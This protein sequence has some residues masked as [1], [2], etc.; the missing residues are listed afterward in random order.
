MNKVFFLF[1]LHNHQPVGN[2]GHIF[3]QA[4]DN[5]YHPLLE[6]LKS[7]PS[8]KM[9]LHHSGPLIEWLEK[10]RPSYFKTLKGMVAKGQ[11][12]ILSGGFYEPILSSLPERDAVGQ[13]KMMNDW[14]KKT[15]NTTPRGAWLAERI[16]DS[17][18]PS[19]LAAAG[20]EYTL[21]DDTHFE[22]AGLSEKDMYGYW[23]TERH[24]NSVAV[25][26]IDKFLRYSIPFKQ[27]EETLK[28]W[29]RAV[30]KHGTIS[31][32]Y[33]DDGEK[34]GVWPETNEWVFGK[35]W[36]ERF[37][38]MV[39]ENSELVETATYS[40]YIDRCPPNGRVYLPPASYEEMMEWSLP[41]EVSK[42]FRGIVDRLEAE[43]RK[44]EFS[45]F[46]RGGQWDN[47]MVK[48]EEANQLHKKMLYISKRAE[49][50]AAK[51]KD[52]RKNSAIRREL[53]QG[54]CNCPYWH[55]LFGGLYLSNLRHA[56]YTH[57]IGSGKLSDA[58]LHKGKKW[59]EINRGDFFKN[60]SEEVAVETSDLFVLIDPAYGG[61]VAEIDYKPASFNISN[62]LTRREESYHHKIVNARD[63]SHG[64]E[65]ILSI[66]DR[67]NMKEEGL[68]TKLLFDKLLRR[69]FMD[70]IFDSP[71]TP[72]MLRTGKAE[73]KGDF[74]SGRYEVVSADKKDGA[75]AVV[76]ARKGTLK[77]ENGDVA[78]KLQKIYRVDA[79]DQKLVCEYKI[80]NI[81]QTTAR[82][83]LA[84]EWNFT[85][86]AAD[87]DDRFITV[88]RKKFKMNSIGSDESLKKWSLTDE[89]FR[90]SLEV[91]SSRPVTL[92]RYP[93]ET[94]SQS[95]GG[96]ESTYQGTCFT[97]LMDVNIAT[98]KTY[99]QKF[100]ISLHPL[101]G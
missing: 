73:D 79:K 66:H 84:V 42:E 54:Q 35:K 39:T 46:L 24:G 98:G 78:L 89:Y 4:Y 63:N 86:L 83:T 14:I 25:F 99:A 74:A 101:H 10:N 32:T 20:I 87:A 28:Y 100:A 49:I 37:L 47:F 95:E 53:Y 18:L 33:G 82:F 90:F 16:W 43:N 52:T 80:K 64:E 55:G 27:P 96:F 40:E 26:P 67:V 15:F 2:F 57:L 19:V 34:F 8:F 50:A 31:V 61:T 85:L 58:I 6:T 97:G 71:P 1:S 76:L 44:E 60:F 77:T 21:L 17:S 45:R 48:Y 81:G 3:E 38:T 7:F 70:K 41:T 23:I 22:Y 51:S 92:L 88:N 75:A 9:S 62:V 65:E 36:L 13:I 56:V 29:R 91:A 59:V 93:I 94:V 11:V 12:E 68:E 72:E 69:S 5:C 30:E